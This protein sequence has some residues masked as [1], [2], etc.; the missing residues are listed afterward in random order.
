[1][2]IPVLLR[3]YHAAIARSDLLLLPPHTRSPPA[4]ASCG[5]CPVLSTSPPGDEYDNDSMAA[6]TTRSGQCRHLYGVTVG[7]G[8]GNLPRRPAVGPVYEY[9]LA[10]PPAATIHPSRR[11]A[12]ATTH[13]ESEICAVCLVVIDAAANRSTNPHQYYDHARAY[14]Y[15]DCIATEHERDPSS[16]SGIPQHI[17]RSG[18]AAGSR[19]R[20][21]ESS[22]AFA[23]HPYHGY[24]HNSLRPRPPPASLDTPSRAY[25]QEKKQTRRQQYIQAPTHVRICK[26][27]NKQDVD[28]MYNAASTT[29]A[30]AATTPSASLSLS[31]FTGI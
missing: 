26:K 27:G 23:I 1:M 30:A 3:P 8:A 6:P 4:T 21:Y 7:T 29:I 13:D 9:D 18:T 11:V 20:V 14:A 17:G 22:D 2:T 5:D 25:L 31:A 12:A 24:N 15:E 19:I 10:A 16:Q 28:N